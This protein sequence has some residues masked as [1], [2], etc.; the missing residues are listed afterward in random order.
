MA[1]IT[2]T[3]DE[4]E[5]KLIS[6]AELQAVLSSLSDEVADRLIDEASAM[7]GQYAGRVLHAQDVTEVLRNVC[8]DRLVLAR[9]PV[10]AIASVTEGTTLVEAADYEFDG[11]LVYRLSNDVRVAW[12]VAKLTVRYTGGYTPIP[13]DL[14]R[15][16]LDL[17]VNLNAMEGR[18]ASVRSQSI[19]DV[20]SISYRDLANGGGLMPDH[21]AKLIDPYREIR[22]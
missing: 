8:T 17:C 3:H 5:S 20:E 1:M 14:K 16:C 6:R 13:A 12:R 4:G 22:L 2:E 11:T 10:T 19:P 7:I 15:A 18:D 21:V 9:W